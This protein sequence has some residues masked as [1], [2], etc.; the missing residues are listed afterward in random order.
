MM[1]KI[2][3]PVAFY[4][5]FS[6]FVLGFFLYARFPSQVVENYLLHSLAERSPGTFLSVGAVGLTFPP[7]LQMENV[8]FGFK[9]NPD[10]LIRMESIR[11]RPRLTGYLAGHA[12]FALGVAA[13]GGILKGRVDFSQWRPE[14]GLKGADIKLEDF[15]LE[16]CEYLKDKLGRRVSGR[17]SGVLKY[18]GDS[19]LDFTV[20]NGSYPLIDN[21]FGFSRVDF[22]KIEGQLSLKGQLLKI[23][24]LRLKGDK[25]NLTLKGDILLN[26]EFRNSE[27]SLSGTVE[28]ATL[29]NKKIPLAI[30]GTIGNAKSRYQ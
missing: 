18:R 24:K 7:G 8:L 20:Q 4:V 3:K 28:I 27:L 21:L 6:I 30:N 17:F 10:S 22:S 23:D 11:V 16:N 12:S 13:Y 26:P 1:R 15:I 2:N 19:Q 29:N 25:I 14:K 9:S 5:V